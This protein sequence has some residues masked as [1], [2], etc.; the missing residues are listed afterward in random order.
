MV[1][2]ERNTP[3]VRKRKRSNK[4]PTTQPT[5]TQARVSRFAASTG[6][7]G[8]L[9]FPSNIND[10][11]SYIEFRRRR[12]TAGNSSVPTGSAIQLYMPAQ[13]TESLSAEYE[14]A[15][16]NINQILGG[17]S[18]VEA[19]T[20]ITDL[21]KSAVDGNADAVTKLM[22]GGLDAAGV[23]AWKAIPEGE[24]GNAVESNLRRVL[25]PSLTYLFKSMG[26]RSFSFSFDMK[27]T[28]EQESRKIRDIIREFKSIQ[29]P[30]VF[31][32]NN[33]GRFLKYPDTVEVVYKN[34]DFL[35][36]FKESVIQDISV[37]YNTTGGTTWSQFSNTAP[38]G[39]QL[40]ITIEELTILTRENVEEGY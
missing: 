15:T 32:P 35:H 11:N 8:A 39:V 36:R 23:A 9:S 1:R 31:D 14:T 29:T 4:M 30:S 24:I 17:K 37:T 25:N 5:Q 21:I 22:Q 26:H 19:G 13:P 6:G 20:A 2:A 33:G 10:F 18:M 28:N 38:V 27:A 34:P 3:A 12:T 16:V 40:D 7:N